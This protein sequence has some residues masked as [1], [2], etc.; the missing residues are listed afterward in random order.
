MEVRPTSAVS[1]VIIAMVGKHDKLLLTRLE[2][3]YELTGSNSVVATE[4]RMGLDSVS[5]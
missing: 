5:V 1:F 4:Y 3:L 2:E